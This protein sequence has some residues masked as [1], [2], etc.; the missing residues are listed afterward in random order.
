VH[1]DLDAR[2]TVNRS[3]RHSVHFPFVHSTQCGPTGLAEAQTPTRG[4]FILGQVLFSADPRERTGTDF[5]VR[6]A[7]AAE[8]LS[9]AGA[10]TASAAAEWRT[11]LITDPAAKTPSG[12][13]HDFLQ[14]L[15]IASIQAR[16]PLDKRQKLAE[17]PQILYFC[18]WMSPA[19]ES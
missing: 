9:T 13:N 17:F 16:L 12:Q 14:E 10:M 7:R 19:A 8:Y 2:I 4:G 18:R 6:G 11:D 15:R 1:V 3:E 5:R